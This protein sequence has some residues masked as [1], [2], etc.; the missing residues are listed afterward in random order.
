MHCCSPKVFENLVLKVSLLSLRISTL[1]KLKEESMYFSELLFQAVGPHRCIGYTW[2]QFA[3]KCS[4][5]VL[6]KSVHS[7]DAGCVLGLDQDLKLARPSQWGG[8]STPCLK[9]MWFLARGPVE[10]ARF[11]QLLVNSQRKQ[12]SNV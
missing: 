2:L 12:I 10:T 4:W 9:Q 5:G 8:P 3:W 11:K 1:T 6:S 7:A